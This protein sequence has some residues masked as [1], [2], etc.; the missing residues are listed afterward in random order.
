ME[1][2]II[3]GLANEREVSRVE[4]EPMG[5]WERNLRHLVGRSMG[6]HTKQ[7]RKVE[8]GPS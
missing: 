6:T 3:E 4:K 7:V 1:Q 8:F 5:P 2:D